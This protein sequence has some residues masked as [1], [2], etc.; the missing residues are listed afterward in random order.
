MSDKDVT[1]KDIEMMAIRTMQHNVVFYTGTM[2]AEQLCSP[3][4]KNRIRPDIY[5]HETNDEGYQR[6]P[7]SARVMDFARFI[8]DN[9]QS[10][11]S[12]IMNARSVEVKF[13]PFQG[14]LNFGVLTV[15]PE[16]NLY[17]VDGQHRLEGLRY[18]FQEKQ[19]SGEK[20]NFEFPV[21]ITNM[22]KYDEALQFAIINRTQKGL[23]TELVD[24]VL[25]KISQ[26]E[27]PLRT[28]KL[29]RII[30]KDI[31]WKTVAMAITDNLKNCEAWKG[32]LQEPNNKKVPSN[33]VTVS[34]LVSSL[35]PIV[36]KFN[37][38]MNQ[39]GTVAE[40]LGKYWEAVGDLCPISVR[41]NPKSSVLMKTLG[42]GVMHLLFVD[43]IRLL[44]DFHED[45]RDRENFREILVKAGEFM[46]DSF[47]NEASVYGSSMSSVSNVYRLLKDPILASYEGRQA[48][49][50]IFF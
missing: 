25:R 42:L 50:K 40:T 36:N 49:Q 21:V 28:Q 15:P 6:I 34:A 44:Q 19:K 4:A 48:A 17:V 8:G 16:G 41:Q 31:G 20:L 29:P 13:R 12:I 47:W 46:T 22:S 2:S 45:R 5:Q 9:R 11:T 27:D 14:T 26:N 30:A 18:L 33:V 38:S 32:R 37:V 3:E 10:P 43:I 23:R 35:E 1:G 7:T 24:L 39:A